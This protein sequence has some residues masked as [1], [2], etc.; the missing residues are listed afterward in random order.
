MSA[1]IAGMISDP[2]AKPARSNFLM[3]D[4]LVG[5]G[6]CT[7]LLAASGDPM[8]TLT[9]KRGLPEETAADGTERPAPGP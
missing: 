4:T 2:T 8:V 9:E 3:T 6:K 1:A 7:R 5:T